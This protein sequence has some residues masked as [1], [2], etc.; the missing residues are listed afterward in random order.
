M[1]G[2]PPTRAKLIKTIA[3]LHTSGALTRPTRPVLALERRTVPRLYQW[4]PQQKFQLKRASWRRR[5]PVD[6]STTPLTCE[7]RRCFDLSRASGL[8]R[9]AASTA[10]S[11]GYGPASRHRR[12]ARKRTP[13][14]AL[15]RCAF[16]RYF[17]SRYLLQRL[18]VRVA[19]PA[20]RK[21]ATMRLDRVLGGVP[22]PVDVA[23]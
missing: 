17:L 11:H 13:F 10:S 14:H 12:A 16:H 15:D 20:R 22:I 23:S 19:P 7:S 9:C 2:S 4:N 21:V 18:D 6:S 3:G 5:P 1:S 8:R